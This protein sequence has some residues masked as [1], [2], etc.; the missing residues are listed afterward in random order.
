[1]DFGHGIR[2]FQ[3]FIKK[4]F[5]GVTSQGCLVLVVVMLLSFETFN[6]GLVYTKIKTLNFYSN[7]INF[8]CNQF[9][10]QFFGN[11]TKFLKLDL[12]YLINQRFFFFAFSKDGSTV[13]L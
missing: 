4:F 3:A 12:K 11:F 13:R 8:F 7:V 10:D 2:I 5:C 6:L 1:M 9:W